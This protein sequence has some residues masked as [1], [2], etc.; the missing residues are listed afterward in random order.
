[1][2]LLKLK[3]QLNRMQAGNTIRIET[4]DMGS[5]RDFDAFCKQA[6][7]ALLAQIEQPA[8]VDGAFTSGTVYGFLIQKSNL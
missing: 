5:I 1:M 3:Q 7:H 8:R 6:G 4:T 2:P